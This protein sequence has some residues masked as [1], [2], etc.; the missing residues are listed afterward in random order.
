[1]V[2]VIVTS[3]FSAYYADSI[4]PSSLGVL[5]VKGSG[6]A[7]SQL[8]RLR[9]DESLRKGESLDKERKAT[10]AETLHQQAGV[11]VRSMGSAPA[12][13]VLR[14]LGGEHV[15]M[16][17]DGLR[18]TD[19]SATSSDHAMATEINSVNELMILRGPRLLL[20]GSATGGGIIQM[21]LYQGGAPSSGWT[22]DFLLSGETGQP[23][24]AL[25]LRNSFG[26][27]YWTGF[28]EATLRNAGNVRT[29]SDIQSNTQSSVNTFG[30]GAVYS[31]SKSRWGWQARNLNNEYGIPGGFT[32]AH[33][34]GVLIRANSLHTGLH[35]T[36]QLERSPRDT[37]EVRGSRDFYKLQEWESADLL[38]VEFGITRWQGRVDWK[39]SGWGLLHPGQIGAQVGHRF[40][41]VGGFAFTPYT[42]S[43]DASVFGLER[44]RL[45]NKTELESSVRFEYNT[46][47]PDPTTTPNRRNAPLQRD[48]FTLAGAAHLI[49]RLHP[50][51]HLGLGMHRSHRAPTVEELYNQG[52]HLA[53]YSFEI[54]NT[55]L[56]SEVGYGLE[57]NYWWRGKEG[58]L[59]LN[60]WTTYYN[61][62]L[63]S[64]NTGDTNWT[65]ILPIYAAIGKS[66]LLW[67]AETHWTKN[68][69]GDF[70]VEQM[71]QASW[72]HYISN[73][74]PLPAMA[75]LR[76]RTGSGW[77]PPKTEIKVIWEKVLAQKRVDIFEKPTSGYHLFHMYFNYSLQG[78]WRHNIRLSVENL[79]NAHWRNHLSR[80][81][82]ISPEKGRNFSLSYHLAF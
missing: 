2:L 73:E 44:R 51:H 62:Y 69:Q 11:S 58:S 54:G 35:F 78:L 4:E 24:A 42:T 47:I 14:G 68:L 1:M 8:Q 10:L 3:G 32:G 18:T 59:T 7:T 75:P 80:L 37:L 29:P 60:A 9:E 36:Q 55:L 22:G 12:R 66:A 5:V 72:G 82:E 30:A 28:G 39:H 67:G 57:S 65:K 17:Q 61:N 15:V 74:A 71:A 13:P 52:P 50:G 38:G 45:T 33:A 25:S 49:H 53:S 63:A 79:A 43:Y 23:G 76:I 20:H 48:F 34:Q 40:F 27:K 46:H 41:S 26:G 19:L 81:R 31:G 64:R 70:F 21:S 6:S 16:L 56:E 77:M